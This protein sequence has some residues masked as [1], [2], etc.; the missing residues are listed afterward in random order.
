MAARMKVLFIAFVVISILKLVAVVVSVSARPSMTH[1]SAAEL[2][3]GALRLPAER[4]D[5][6]LDDALDAAQQPGVL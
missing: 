1:R 5:P 4:D 3:D 6:A 2:V